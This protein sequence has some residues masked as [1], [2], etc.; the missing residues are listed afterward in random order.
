VLHRLAPS[1][2]MAGY[3][4]RLQAIERAYPERK[5]TLIGDNLSSHKSRPIQAW[6]VE[7]PRNQPRFIPIKAAWHNLMEPWWRL[8]RREALAGQSFADTKEVNQAALDAN[9]RLNVR[10]KP[11]VWGRPARIP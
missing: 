11:W 2:N 7:H 4:Q 6:L 3:L 9:R 1:R 8:L 5:L 10:A